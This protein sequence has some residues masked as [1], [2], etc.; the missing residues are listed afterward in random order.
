MTKK[1]QLNI[2]LITFLF[3]LFLWQPIQC[4]S[5]AGNIPYNLSKPYK[6]I[7]L[8][9]DLNEISGIVSI[10]DNKIACIEDENGII[11]I[12][13]F[14]KKTIEEKIKFGGIGDYEDLA[15]INGS[16]F[17][18]KSNGTLIEYTQGKTVEYSTPLSKYNNTEGMC[19]DEKKQRL[20]ISCKENPRLVFAF[21][22]KSKKLNSDPLL[23]ISLK[24]F[25]PTGLALDKDNML[26]SISGNG[27]LAVFTKTFS[28]YTSIKLNQKAFPQPEG[29][30]F[31]DNG[32]LLISNEGQKGNATLYLFKRDG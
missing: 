12:Y 13:N 32:D 3:L 19:Y 10:G 22:L 8:P 2:S 15:Y 24:G 9:E 6:T 25:N 18:L 17:V 30:T 29:I 26:Y 7:H 1:C 23:E 11:Y 4:T 16:Y 14:E 20:L 5:K 28:I 27:Q 21:D 31:L